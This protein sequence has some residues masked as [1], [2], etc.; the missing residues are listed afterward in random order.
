MSERHISVC[1]ACNDP[2]PGPIRRLYYQKRTHGPFFPV[3]ETLKHG[4]NASLFSGG[5]VAVCTGCSSHLQRQW[6]AFEKNWT[7]LEK[8]SYTLLAGT[9][10]TCSN[11][12]SETF[13]YSVII[14]CHVIAAFNLR[15]TKPSKKICRKPAT[16]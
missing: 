13:T 16:Q 14:S 2:T 12:N 11:I 9:E 15:I 1:V 4:G 3:L 6:T 8:R 5:R 7:P 10:L